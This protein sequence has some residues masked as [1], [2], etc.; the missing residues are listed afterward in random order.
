MAWTYTNNPSGVQR[1][2]VRFLLGDTDV[3]DQLVTD[4]EIAY[5]ISVRGSSLGAAI[6]ACEALEA[7]Y[8]R[9]ADQRVG[10]LSLSASQK[11]AGFRALALT[12][13]RR[14]TVTAIPY[15]GGITVTDKQAQELDTDRVLPAFSR[16][17]MTN[18]QGNS[19]IEPQI[20]EE[21]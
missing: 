7:R 8:A 17:M 18:P 20:R 11:A 2:E 16:D 1:D 4:E 19:V 10:F 3:T 21:E 5:L 13:R 14:Q 9:E 12:L 15:A 6:G